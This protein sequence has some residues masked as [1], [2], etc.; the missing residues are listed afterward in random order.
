MTLKEFNKVKSKFIHRSKVGYMKI[1]PS[2]LLFVTNPTPYQ[3]EQSKHDDIFIRPQNLR[4]LDNYFIFRTESGQMING[5]LT[6][7]TQKWTI[8]YNHVKSIHNVTYT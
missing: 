2:G 6:D 3:I 8:P 5:I 4:I 7:I 1:Y